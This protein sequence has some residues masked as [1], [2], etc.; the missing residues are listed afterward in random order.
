MDLV[1]DLG[2]TNKKLALFQ[3]G[4]L[5]ELHLFPDI[6]VSLIRDFIKQYPD[7]NRCILSSVIKH[8]VSLNH[9]LGKQY[10]FLELDEKT[11]VPVRNLYN[12]PKTLGNDRLAAAVAGASIFPGKDVLIINMGS[13][14]TYDFINSQNEYLGGSISPGMQMRFMALNTFTGKLP[15]VKPKEAVELI[16]SNTENSVLSGVING[17]IHEMEGTVDR[18]REKYHNLKVILSGGDLIYFDKRL[19][20]SIFAVPNIVLQGLYQILAFNVKKTN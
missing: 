10:E 18:Y 9:F 20:I 4:K 16:G 11:P 17:I 13:C 6:N 14:I 19:K 12:Q 3:D 8:P 2:N 1:I 5:S 7:I 15:L